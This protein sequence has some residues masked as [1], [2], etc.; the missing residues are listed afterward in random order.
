MV[1]A[2]FVAMWLALRVA[3]KYSNFGRRRLGEPLNSDNAINE[4][5]SYISQRRSAPPRVLLVVGGRFKNAIGDTVNFA[6]HLR[7]LREAFGSICTTVWGADDSLWK[8]LCSDSVSCRPFIGEDEAVNGFDLVVFDWVEVSESIESIYAKSEVAL[9][10]FSRSWVRY[11]L[12]GSAWKQLTLPPASNHFRRLQMAY[13]C[14]GI[15]NMPLTL[16]LQPTKSLDEEALES[17]IHALVGEF[18]PR[19]VVCPS[20]PQRVLAGQELAYQN[21]A[22]VV[23]RAEHS[24]GIRVLKP[25]TVSEYIARVRTAAVVIGP[26]TSTQHI[27]NYFG[28]PSIACYPPNAGFRF[29]Y[30]GCPGPQNLCFRRPSPIQAVEVSEF[31]SL[32]AYIARSLMTN[33]QNLQLELCDKYVESCR[34]IARGDVSPEHGA[35]Q[36]DEHLTEMRSIIPARWHCFIFPELQTLAQE[37]CAIARQASLNGHD[38]LSLERLNDIFAL[39]TVRAVS[40]MSSQISEEVANVAWD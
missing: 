1:P 28:V 21:L 23:S 33:K 30:W 6:Y 37:V 2:S 22:N 26:D 38:T 31:A 39:K 29:Y 35:T 4:I 24:L 13:E 20:P 7:H 10:D 27:A 12:G 17:L 9:L 14:L 32:V 5:R 15:T 25:L 40:L 11:R 3:A 34:D 19:R 16:H 18:H 8:A 36:I